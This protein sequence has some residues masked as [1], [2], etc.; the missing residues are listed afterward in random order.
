M[1]SD[2]EKKHLSFYYVHINS[3]AASA[4]LFIQCLEFAVPEKKVTW[5]LKLR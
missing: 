3:A 1:E 5:L 4:S 2:H